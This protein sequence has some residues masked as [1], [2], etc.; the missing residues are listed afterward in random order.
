QFSTMSLALEIW[1]G[2]FL[3]IFTVVTP[4]TII[5]GIAALISRQLPA[6]KESV[7]SILYKLRITGIKSVMGINRQRMGFF[8]VVAFAFQLFLTLAA[9]NVPHISYRLSYE[10]IGS[11]YAT[12]YLDVDEKTAEVL[13]KTV[14]YDLEEEIEESWKYTRITGFNN[15]VGSRV[16]LYRYNVSSMP[17]R[18]KASKT[19]RSLLLKASEEQRVILLTTGKDYQSSEITVKLRENQEVNFSLLDEKLALPGFINDEISTST[20]LLFVPEPIIIQLLV[21]ISINLSDYS[22]DEQ[23][24]IQFFSDNKSSDLVK[25]KIESVVFQ[26]LGNWITID[27]PE[28]DVDS[29]ITFYIIETVIFSLFL[30]ISFIILFISEISAR[31]AEFGP[32]LCRGFSFRMLRI[33]LL[34]EASIVVVFAAVFAWVVAMLLVFW[35]ALM[36]QYSSLNPFVTPIFPLENQLVFLILVIF[37]IVCYSVTLKIIIKSGSLLQYMKQSY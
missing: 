18:Y 25:S 21:P 16:E 14:M 3:T 35:L 8:V 17:I 15:K 9:V 24:R 7:N 2:I 23:I 33:A 10:M 37:F 29:Q 5:I 22:F 19:V 20:D 31:K 1:L 6:I 27:Y 28:G 4:I 36:L 34:V 11:S 32:Y 30:G 12:E 13:A 26:Q